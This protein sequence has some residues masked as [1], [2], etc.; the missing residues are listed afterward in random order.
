MLDAANNLI[1]PKQAGELEMRAVWDGKG[2]WW[3]YPRVFNTGKTPLLVRLKPEEG[4]GVWL[5]DGHRNKPRWRPK[6]DFYWEVPLTW[7]GDVIRRSVDRYGAAIA[8]KPSASMLE[9]CASACWDA[10]SDVTEC[11][12]SC[13]GANHGTNG[14]PG[15]YY[16]INEALAVKWT[17]NRFYTL[18]SSRRRTARPAR[19]GPEL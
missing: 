5:R 12:C 19:R 18:T 9:K 14:N 10:T 11:T 6:P 13:G 1:L 17:D 16:E 8:I 3:D 4:I 2:K 15:G 7:Q